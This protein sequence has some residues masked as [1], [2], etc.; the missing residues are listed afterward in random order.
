[1]NRRMIYCPGPER[2]ITIGHYVRGVKLAKANL[3]SEFKQGITCW[4]PCTGREIVRQFAAG[5]HDRINQ[6]I[7][8]TARKTVQV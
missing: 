4:W 8:Y 3:D 6:A 2:W 5:M 1:M 7:P